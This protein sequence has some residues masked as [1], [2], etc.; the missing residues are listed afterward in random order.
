M[1]CSGCASQLSNRVRDNL[2]ELKLEAH[3]IT[4]EDRNRH[5]TLSGSVS[6]QLDKTRIEIATAHT[7]GVRSVDNLLR[8]S[9]AGA[10]GELATEIRDRIANSHSIS[11]YRITVS[12]SQDR[13]TLKGTVRT[14]PEADEI[15][16]IARE[17]A[18]VRS[19]DNQL[20][21][22]AHPNRSL[23]LIE[24][25]RRSLLREADIDLSTIIITE[26][27]GVLTFHGRVTNHIALDRILSHTLMIEG[28]KDVRSEVKVLHVS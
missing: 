19:I 4:I 22:W 17:S 18:G 27:D 21:V 24:R 3:Q 5:I 12:T 16:R 25:V 23:P 9:S 15:E 26:R 2:D 10:S 1:I 20:I 13:V 6:S 8:V 14:H 28:V 11:D 7:E